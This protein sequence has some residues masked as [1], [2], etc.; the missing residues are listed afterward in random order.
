MRD[1]HGRLNARHRDALVAEGVNGLS[2]LN[3]LARWGAGREALMCYGK[4]HHKADVHVRTHEDQALPNADLALH[5]SDEVYVQAWC[6]GMA[7]AEA[8]AQILGSPCR[9]AERVCTWKS[10]KAD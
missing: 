7:Q 10:E 3:T 8:K 5:Q 9:A 2:R 6:N 4:R 1:R